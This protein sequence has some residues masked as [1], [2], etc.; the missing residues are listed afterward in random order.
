MLTAKQEA[1]AQAIAAGKSQA[2]AYREAYSAGGMSD[3]AIYREASVLVDNPKVA[4][5]VTALKAELAKRVLWT[6]EMSVKALAKLYMADDTP[7]SSK[8]AA[9]RELNL[10][11]GYNEPTQVEVAGRQEMVINIKRATAGNAAG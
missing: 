6:K 3:N 8:V 2:E 1:F 4:Q 7:A 11:H 10:M 5:R 9:I